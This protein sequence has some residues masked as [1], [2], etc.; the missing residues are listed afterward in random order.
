MCLLR[1]VREPD[2]LTVG[3][4][5]VGVGEKADVEVRVEARGLALGD[6]QHT[7]APGWRRRKTRLLCRGARRQ[8]QGEQDQHGG[9]DDVASGHGLASS[10]LSA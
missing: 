7:A 2:E 3:E 5:H 10:S 4:A 8:G 1:T 9:D 6:A